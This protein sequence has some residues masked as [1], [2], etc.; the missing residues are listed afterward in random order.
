MIQAMFEQS[1]G[2]SRSHEGVL[3]SWMKILMR[4][5]YTASREGLGKVVFQAAEVLL[6]R[7]ILGV[8]LVDGALE[9]A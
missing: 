6:G 4:R 9:S 8:T 5:R 7:H 2:G 1:A 3:N